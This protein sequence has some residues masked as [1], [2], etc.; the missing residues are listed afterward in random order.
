MAFISRDRLNQLE[1]AEA[2]RDQLLAES[3]EWERAEDVVVEAREL[4]GQAAM[5]TAT[6]QDARTQVVVAITASER[7][8][9][10]ADLAE[11]IKEKERATVAAKVRVEEGPSITHSLKQTFREDGTFDRIRSEVEASVRAEMHEKVL[12]DEKVTIKAELETPEEREKYKAT[13]LQDDEFTAELDQYRAQVQSGLESDWSSEAEAEAKQKIDAEEL[14]R[15]D[16]Y[17][18][19]AVTTI[20]SGDWAN[21]YRDQKR[22]ALEGEWDGVAKEQVAAAIDDKELKALLGEIANLAKAKLDKE[23]RAEKLLRAFEGKGIHIAELEPETRVEIFL[24]TIGQFEVPEKYRDTWGDERTRNVNKPGVACKRRLVLLAREDE[25]FVVDDDSLLNADSEYARNDALQ[26]G[27]VITIGRKITHNREESL[28]N[29]VVADVPL[30][31][32]DDTSEPHITD[33]LYPVA[34]IKIDGISA[35]GIEHV[36][37]V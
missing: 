19:D 22:R 6:E 9:L 33:A 23:V 29:V 12:A 31:Y 8:R 1:Q 24:G 26:R 4:L 13:L 32:D 2:Q 34:D 7:E 20:M 36:E 17:I 18:A 27:T 14:A 25:F 11:G 16:S 37:M 5:V 15:K 28:E 10:T 30:Y 21:R 3:H 35:R